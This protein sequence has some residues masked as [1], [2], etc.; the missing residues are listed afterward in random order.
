MRL[1]V[2]VCYLPGEFFWEQESLTQSAYPVQWTAARRL[3]VFD[4]IWNVS[5]NLETTIDAASS[6]LNLENG[7]DDEKALPIERSSFFAACDFLRR[8]AA[9]F[10][11]VMAEEMPIPSLSPVSD[12]GVDAH[13]QLAKAELL[14][15]FHPGNPSRP[16][17]YGDRYGDSYIKGRL[18]S[19]ERNSWLILWLSAEHE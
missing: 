14:L 3:R 19:E 7:W 18:A 5:S 16:T 2:A 4:K 9:A 13:W 17:F 6:M 12:G 8:I 15:H 10:H 11:S 1:E